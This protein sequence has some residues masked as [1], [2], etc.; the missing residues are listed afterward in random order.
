MELLAYA[1]LMFWFVI[2]AALGSFLNV[3][4]WRVPRGE[5]L[6]RPGSHCTSCGTPIKAR[7]N[8]PIVGWFVLRGR[9]AACGQPFS[10]RYALIEAL[11]ALLAAALHL[12]VDA[13]L[14]LA[15]VPAAYGLV[16]AGWVFLVFTL[17][18]VVLVDAAFFVIPGVLVTPGI[19]VGLA[20]PL[21]VGLTGAAPPVSFQAAGIGAAAG[22][23][24]LLLIALAFL[25]LRKKEGMGEGDVL[26][27]TL[28]G[29]FLGPAS[30]L[31]VLLASSVQGLVFTALFWGRV[32]DQGLRIPF[33]P[34]LA[35]AA[36][37][38]LYLSDWLIEGF[39]RWSGLS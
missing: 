34:F 9:C 37:E 26:L 3:V 5:S 21:L 11:M 7:H 20:L 14:P 16:M 23:G 12:R 15:E 10:I 29:A 13:W 1:P 35:L 33:G 38:W 27:V 4:A 2:G 25:V 19:A 22:G 17:L 6:I 8:L 36:I 18:A 28:I 24:S 39:Q 30:L 31:F 32:R